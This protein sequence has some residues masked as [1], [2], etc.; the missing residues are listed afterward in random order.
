MELF[1]L[2][3]PPI[4]SPVWRS[5]SSGQPTMSEHDTFKLL[6][7]S[8]F[9]CGSNESTLEYDLVCNTAIY[10]LLLELQTFSS[11]TIPAPLLSGILLSCYQ[12]PKLFSVTFRSPYWGPIQCVRSG[13]PPQLQCRHEKTKQGNLGG[14]VEKSLKLLPKFLT[15]VSLFLPV[16][17]SLN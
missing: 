16:L 11:S 13:L 2:S 12:P 17:C 10:L 5:R 8:V 4:G 1:A 14:Y 3:E 6:T 7:T 9:K 15:T